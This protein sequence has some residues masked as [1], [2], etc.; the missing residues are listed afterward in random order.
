[1]ALVVVI[2]LFA[3]SWETT[4]YNRVDT[5]TKEQKETIDYFIEIRGQINSTDKDIVDLYKKIHPGFEITF[6]TCFALIALELLLRLIACPCLWRYL[7]SPIHLCEIIASINFWLFL[8]TTHHLEDFK[9]MAGYVFFTVT[10]L[11]II[12][13][14]F[15]LVRIANHSNTFKVMSL[16]VS[17]SLS[18]IAVL[19]ALLLIFVSM[20][21]WLMYIVEVD[22][23]RFDSFFTAMYWALITLTTVGYGDYYPATGF[24]HVVAGACAVAGLVTLAL[25]IGVIAASFSSYYSHHKYVSHHMQTY[26]PYKLETWR[27]FTE[28]MIQK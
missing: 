6:I 27:R 5:R 26:R 23:D 1:M 8:Y 13:Q 20:F 18:E 24:G 9:S 16:S 11:L 22:N 17:S 15:H 28:K 10:R 2:A 25:P 3:L 7:K 19:C 14:V 12:L 21:G 4:G